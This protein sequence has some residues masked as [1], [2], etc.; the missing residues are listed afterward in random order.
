MRP[1]DSLFSVYIYQRDLPSFF[2]RFCLSYVL[3]T[4]LLFL[5][6]I[7]FM[8]ASLREPQCVMYH[9]G[10]NVFCLSGIH[11]HIRERLG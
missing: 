1:V 8:S 6:L 9:S 2:P 5:T 4:I 3:Y 10:S 11:M 7:L